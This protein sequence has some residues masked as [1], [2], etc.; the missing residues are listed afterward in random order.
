MDATVLTAKE[1]I[2]PFV[3]T[4]LF[5]RWNNTPMESPLD[6]GDLAL[7]AHVVDAGSFTRAAERLSVPK[8]T[9]SRR[10]SALEARLG[11]RLIRRTTR[12]LVVTDFGTAVL[13][14][15]RQVVA[16]VDGAQALAAHRQAQ[17]SGHL[18]VSMPADMAM[19]ALGSAIERFVQD[20]PAVT[21]TLDLSPRRVDLLAEGY[22]LALRMGELPA[23]SQLG[24]RRLAWFAAG[25][26]ASPAWVA[27]HG[28]PAH[29]DALMSGA[30]QALLVAGQ[31]GEAMPWR[32]VRLDAQREEAPP[33]EAWKALPPARMLANAPA[34]LLQLAR[35]GL[36]VALVPDFFAAPSVRSG[37]LVRV[38]PDWRPAPSA[39]WAVFPERRL[40]PAK[41]RAFIDA[42]VA[43][44]APCREPGVDV[45]A[46]AAAAAQPAERSS[47]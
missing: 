22:D 14:H 35:A 17:P 20:H 4:C 21:L 30:P 26:F 15:A 5:H 18:K 39:A 3:W 41:T 33:L 2:K 6:P 28:Q 44:L 16:E 8:S 38:L 24:A 45:C 40:M 36:G 12:R 27:A 19:L 1:R 11:E 46:A 29:P 31:G 43:A 47:R 10:L 32:L 9:V 34:L 23:D 7:F 13:A 42:L 37:E 25:L